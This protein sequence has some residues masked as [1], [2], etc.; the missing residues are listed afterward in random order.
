MNPRP[1]LILLLASAIIA[2]VSGCAPIIPQCT[3]PNGAHAWGAWVDRTHEDGELKT[4]GSYK[5]MQLRN[6]VNCN[7]AQR[8]YH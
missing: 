8:G 1:L 4:T 3:T 7:V 2:G 5:I 6:C